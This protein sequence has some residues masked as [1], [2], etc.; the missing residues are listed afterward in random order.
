[1]GRKKGEGEIKKVNRG[2][3]RPM[4]PM[5]GRRF[6]GMRVVLPTTNKLLRRWAGA[7]VFKDCASFRPRGSQPRPERTNRAWS[8]E[9]HC[10]LR[11]LQHTRKPQM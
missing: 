9:R 3:K 4:G 5:E 8:F 7:S 11:T 2:E 1:M 6:R 10:I